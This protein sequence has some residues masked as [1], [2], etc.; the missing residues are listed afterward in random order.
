MIQS[1][2]IEISEK[3]TKGTYLPMSR[4]LTGNK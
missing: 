4:P 3:K 2:N 1:K